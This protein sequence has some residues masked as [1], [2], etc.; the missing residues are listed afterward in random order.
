MF[1]S[2]RPTIDISP[3][4][5]LVDQCDRVYACGWGGI[6]N[7]AL[8]DAPDRIDNNGFTD[9]MPTTPNAVR[10]TSD[11]PGQ[12]SDFYLAQFTPGLTA[13]SYG[14]YYGN[15]DEGSEGDHVDGGTSRFDPRGV[16]YA[17]VC[18]CFSYSGFPVPP[19]ANTY[20]PISGNAPNRGYGPQCN[21]SAFKLNFEPTNVTT[22]GDL[23]VCAT[24]A[25]V[26]LLGLPGGGIWTG[27]GVSGSV[28]D[29]YVFTP[30]ATLQGV[31]TLTYTL[32]GA[33]QAC[34]A[35][36]QKLVTV[37]PPTNA[38]LA[39]MP[40]TTF[41]LQDG[42]APPTITLAATPAGGTFSGPGVQGNVFSPTL[43]GPGI[44]TITYSVG[45]GTPCPSSASVQLT[46]VKAT[47]GSSFTLCANNGPFA[48]PAGNPVGGTWA[49]PGVSGSVAAGFTYTPDPQLGSTTQQLTY[50]VPSPA[51][52]CVATAL[53]TATVVGAPQASAAALPNVCSNAAP[54]ALTGGQPAGGTWTG[55]GVSGSVAA[56]FVFTPSAALIGSQTLT[57]T[58]QAN[59]VCANLSSQA[60]TTLTVAPG[61]TVALP[62]DTLLCP[63]SRQPF[64][65]LAQPAG[66]T[67][68]GPG[69]AGD[70]FDPLA[71]GT[72]T[73]TLTYAVDTG[74]LCATAGTRRVTVL[75]TPTLTPVLLPEAC[76]PAAV[77]P[78]LVHYRLDAATLPADAQLAWHFGDDSTAVATGFDVTHAYLQA[79]TF[80]PRLELRLGNSGCT[81][82]QALAPVTV[83]K[84]FVPNVI[85]PN[86]DQ[87]NDLF[88]PR[89]GGC[90]PRLQVYSR[91]GQLVYEDAAYQNTW[92]G[93]TLGPGVYYYLLTP[94]DGSA[95]LKGWVELLR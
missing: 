30:I 20:S 36:G 6:V 33:T 45:V 66:G 87:K 48:L 41:C 71:A 61:Q 59:Q 7:K 89:I 53:V 81:Q 95:K 35:T 68:S 83:E 4:A 74:Q 12:G 75:P 39:A 56:G 82:S 2:G 54:L 28:A 16:V 23:A 52:N 10:R 22:G 43:A 49:G 8:Y 42:T 92:D 15:P 58:V 62:A 72:G 44:H 63:G 85:T 79:G 51:G 67:W 88:A 31:Q 50:S 94:P 84:M 69:V 73:F 77:A 60:T 29:G 3:T 24:G 5:F 13:L 70:I 64:R 40:L 55:P 9:D 21:N 17:A 76:Q 80:H 14:T 46:V 19:G 65:L 34:V 91:W 18:S 90:P 25:P 26:P 11:S 38:T 1:G 37:G 78:Y 57:Y 47:A 93:G 32:T 27:P 86:A